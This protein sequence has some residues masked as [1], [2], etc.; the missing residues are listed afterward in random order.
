MQMRKICY[1]GLFLA[2]ILQACKRDV[3]ELEFPA[4]ARVN[5]FNAAHYPTPY[6][7]LDV[8]DTAHFKSPA[9]F[10]FFGRNSYPYNMPASPEVGHGAIA[11]MSLPAGTHQFYFAD[12]GKILR[13]ERSLALEAGSYTTL[14][15]TDSLLH[16]DVLEVP[17]DPFEHHPGKVRIRIINLVP[18]VLL[19]T[20][21]IAGDG[22]LYDDDLPREIPYKTITAAIEPG[23]EQALNGN[24]FFRFYHEGDAGEELIA[25][26]PAIRAT[27]GR[28]YTIVV[29]GYRQDYAVPDAQFKKGITV[30]VRVDN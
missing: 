15:L 7:A 18:D 25:T 2:I 4:D 20:K 8:F 19:N 29:Q 23:M 24:F 9:V 28:T 10:D 26:V 11:Y 12:T 5:F 21:M 16:Y 6:I 30:T 14:Y 22:S 3:N 17:A 1:Y 13:T 27:P